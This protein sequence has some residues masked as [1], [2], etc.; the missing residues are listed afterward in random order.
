MN[1]T[2]QHHIESLLPFYTIN[3]LAEHNH[4]IDAW[5]CIF[6]QIYDITSLVK[7]VEGTSIYQTLI[8]H[9]GEDISL[10][11]DEQTHE[12]RRRIDP[13]TYQSVLLVPNLSLLESFD[14]P[15][16]KSTD[17]L[18][19][20]LT[21]HSR[22]IRLLH[23]SF[24]KQP[25]L[26]EVAEEETIGQI[27]RKFLKFNAHIFSYIWQYNGRIL[28]WNRTLT[29]NGIVNEESFHDQFGWRSDNENCPTILLHFSDDL[30]SA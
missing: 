19:G 15:F 21:E 3:E 1:Q 14:P 25:Y 5:I 30:T 2:L 27:A 11:F 22:Y 9:A 12:P 4:S 20:R 10:W 16:W 23:T 7:K 8:D 13:Q 26:L 18:I 29:E 28:D 17:L 6:T 24:P